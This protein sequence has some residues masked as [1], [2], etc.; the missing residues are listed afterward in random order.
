MHICNFEVAS[1]LCLHLMQGI[2]KVD[3][4]V[5]LFPDPGLTLQSW[6]TPVPG[7]WNIWTRLWKGMQLLYR[8]NTL[9][10][11]QNCCHF[12]D[13]RFKCIFQN[14]NVWISLKFV[15][16]ILINNI[17]ALIQIMAWHRPETSHYLNQ[18]WLVYWHIYASLGFNEWK[19]PAC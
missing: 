18:R 17:P 1:P 14:E 10:P 9:R 7:E 12:T 16:K 15:P 13:A 6:D 11:R 19:M 3:H 8:V 2:F 5:S 4:A